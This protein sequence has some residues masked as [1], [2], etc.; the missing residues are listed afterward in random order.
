MEANGFDCGDQ[1]SGEL[2]MRDYS[3]K[4]W[5]P[6]IEFCQTATFFQDLPFS[7]PQTTRELLEAYPRAKFILTQRLSTDAWYQSICRFH[8]IF[9]KAAGQTPTAEEL[10]AS[11]YRYP[12]FAW[13]ANRA[14]YNSPSTDPYNERILKNC[15]EVHNEEIKALFAGND[16]FL[17][18]SIEDSNAIPK[19]EA[20]LDI[21]SKINQ[22]PWLNKTASKEP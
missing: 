20:F 4:N 17:A 19:L 6:I 15:Y 13:E 22:M 10:K 7:A 8:K 2:L 12:G 9:F 18:L 16:N 11:P 1:A 21:K 14:L 5:K 3:N